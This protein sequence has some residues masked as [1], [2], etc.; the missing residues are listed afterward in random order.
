MH[1]L[2]SRDVKH[3]AFATGTFGNY[4][5]ANQVDDFLDDMEATLRHYEN[6]AVTQRITDQLADA[7]AARVVEKL[8]A[9]E[10]DQ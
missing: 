5:D 7:I 1:F 3:K 9:G 6:P 10:H 2:T 8:K 4:Y